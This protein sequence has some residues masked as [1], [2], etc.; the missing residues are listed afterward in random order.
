MRWDEGAAQRLVIEQLVAE[1]PERARVQ[2]LVSQFSWDRVAAQIAD[3]YH[4]HVQ[5]HGASLPA[6]RRH[7]V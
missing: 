2:A 3:C 1:Q 4:G 5:L 7:A 6:G